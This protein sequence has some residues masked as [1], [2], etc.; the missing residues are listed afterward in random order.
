MLTLCISLFW[1]RGKIVKYSSFFRPIACVF[2]RRL[3]VCGGVTVSLFGCVTVWNR[4]LS[5]CKYFCQIPT[6]IGT[7][8]ISELYFYYYS[9]VEFDTSEFCLLCCRDLPKLP[10]WNPFLSLRNM[11]SVLQRMKGLQRFLEM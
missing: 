8:L 2:V 7:L 4:T 11:E 5:F 6:I 9:F 10:P 1:R 3:P